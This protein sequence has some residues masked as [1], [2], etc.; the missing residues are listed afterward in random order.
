MNLLIILILF[1]VFFM[2]LPAIYL[3][4][5][6]NF[7]IIKNKRINGFFFRLFFLFPGVFLFEFLVFIFLNLVFISKSLSPSD[8]FYWE[9]ILIVSIPT[10]GLLILFFKKFVLR[11]NFPSEEKNLDKFDLYIFIPNRRKI[12]DSSSYRIKGRF[13]SIRIGVQVRE[14]SADFSKTNEEILFT[15]RGELIASIRALNIFKGNKLTG[16]EIKPVIDKENKQESGLYFQLIASELHPLSLKT[17]FLKG[18]FGTSLIDE[19]YVYYNK[20]ILLTVADF[21]RTVEYVGS[22]QGSPYY[23][24][25]LWIVTNKTMKVLINELNQNKRDFI[26]VHLIDD[27]NYEPEK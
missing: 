5:Q 22:N 18:L 24:Q 21:G 10:S 15:K 6:K 26:P 2:V 8:L 13:G 4:K 17:V 27:E 12:D 9:I 3:A 7:L 1:S 25:R 11:T 19:D 14:L 23:P 16:Y 20:N